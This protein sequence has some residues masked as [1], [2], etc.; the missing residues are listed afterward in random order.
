M[1]R[2]IS[3]IAVVAMLL[4]MT[5]IFASCGGTATPKDV[6]SSLVTDGN[7]NV[8]WKLKYDDSDSKNPKYTLYIT[9]NSE[10]PVPMLSS[11]V[12]E[13][14][15]SGVEKTVYKAKTVKSADEMPWKDYR[16]SITHVEISNVTDIPD[17]AFYGMTS[18]KSVKFVD[19]NVTKIG[20]QAFIF[21]ASLTSTGGS[22]FFDI[23]EG[24][25]EI[26]D[27]AFEGC[28]AL[29]KVELPSTTTKVGSKAF[30]YAYGLKTLVKPEA[31]TLPTDAFNILIGKEIKKN[32]N[33]KLEALKA[34]EETPPEAT[35]P[36]PDATDTT[37]STDAPATSK[38]TD[39]VKKEEKTETDTT[40]TIIAISIMAVVIIGVI[41]GA[42]LLMRSNKKQTNDA[43]TVRKNDNEKA[44][45][46]GK[47]ASSKNGKNAKNGKKGKKK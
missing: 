17:Y 3:I 43:R 33:V 45:K 24:V 4:T 21:C 1:K 13:K 8:T 18:L 35:T 26:G 27:S 20:K 2:I 14:D 32:P 7:N 30:A 39:S 41:I 22:D 31:L 12:K 5:A 28:S 23:P 11:P 42:I 44:N 46:N 15:E 19:E 16:T 36:A 6:G 25:T 40:T 47:N 29:T 37:T 9:G 10:N 34:K 38:T